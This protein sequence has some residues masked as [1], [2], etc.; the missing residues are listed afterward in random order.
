M[1]KISMNK[2]EEVA[3]HWASKEI[4]GNGAIY[5]PK[6]FDDK[7][8]LCYILKCV[9]NKSE[10]TDIIVFCE[11]MNDVYL[12]RDT[13]KIFDHNEGNTLLSISQK[14]LRLRIY[15]N[16]MIQRL[17]Y[18]TEPYLVVFYHPIGV[19][20]PI[21]AIF[22]KSK[23]RLILLDKYPE[24]NLMKDIIALSTF[25]DD[26][27]QVSVDN[28]VHTSCPVEEMLVAIPLDESLQTA[29]NLRELNDYISTSLNIFGSFDIMTQCR[30]GNPTI[31][32]SAN[33]MCSRIADSNGWSDSLDMSLEVNKQIDELY[34]PLSIKERASM[35]Y[36]FIRTRMN[37]L[38]DYTGKLEE[39]Y[40][41]V[42]EN[43]GSNILIISKRSEFAEQVTQYLNERYNFEIC[44]SYHNK[45]EPI[46]GVD[47]H[48]N[49]VYYK[50]GKQKGKRKYLGEQAQKT[51]NEQKFATGRA[52][53]MS[54]NNAPDKDLCIG[55]D[56]VIITSPLCETIEAYMYR[57]DK[58][59]IS[60]ETLKLY[61]L[62][63]KN[64]L[65]NQRLNNRT[66]GEHHK[67]IN[68]K[69]DYKIENNSDFILVD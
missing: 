48:G 16:N 18:V 17:P 22:G 60:S 27:T 32:L 12:I 57:L 61:T 68:E 41:I 9:L 43:K 7:A 28:E 51:L 62:Y 14:N 23:F 2:I 49:P 5:V 45:M 29:I 54:T 24:P 13:C 10:D 21:K 67:V 58:V 6:P 64:S 44:V 30:L 31:N 19:T 36:E 20:S 8:L 46:P 15:T 53:V 55:I 25:M 33:E 50:S 69:S 37:L 3:R 66:I 56:T 42:E 65:E 1:K 34:N 59:Y 39:I 38:S 4:K 47:I 40:K 26:F 11:T 35:T 52:R 63:V